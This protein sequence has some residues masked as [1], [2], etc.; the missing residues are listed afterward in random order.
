MF[1]PAVAELQPRRVVSETRCVF[2]AATWRTHNRRHFAVIENIYVES[3][4]PLPVPSRTP[5]I[6]EAE[7]FAACTVHQSG[8]ILL[9]TLVDLA[10][11]KGDKTSARGRARA[12][13]AISPEAGTEAAVYLT[14]ALTV[15]L[16]PEF[17][18]YGEIQPVI[19]QEP[20]EA[21]RDLVRQ[22][23]DFPAERW[24]QIERIREETSEALERDI[25]RE[26]I[27]RG[28]HAGAFEVDMMRMKFAWEA[29]KLSGLN[30]STLPGFA[31]VASTAMPLWGEIGGLDWMIVHS[32]NARIRWRYGEEAFLDTAFAPWVEDP[33]T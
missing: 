1:A 10:T 18:P 30:P 19:A 6:E 12:W 4:C 20:I 7:L 2:E 24:D 28:G 11:M 5:E 33:Q 29:L 8:A 13:N 15:L 16:R 25:V 27:E 31:P 21:A 17:T 9:P 3:G 23:F 32:I 22:T 26:A 14:M